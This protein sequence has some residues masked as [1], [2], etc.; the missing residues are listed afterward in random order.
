MDQF[1]LQGKVALITGASRGIGEAIA[2]TFAK[3]GA[4]VIVASRHLDNLEVVV[5]TI[6]GNGGEAFAIAAHMGDAGAGKLLVQQSIDLFGGID[7]VVNNAGI[8]PYWGSLLEAEESLWDKTLDVNLKGYFRLIREATPSMIERGGG[9]VINIASIAGLSPMPGVGLYGISKAAVIMLT[10][11]L[12]IELAPNNI[13]VNAIAPGFVKTR[14]SQAIWG[15][16]TVNQAVIDNT[17]AKRIADV[18]ELM[19]LALYLATPASQYLTGQ[20]IVIDGG[21]TLSTSNYGD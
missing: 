4:Q 7:V 2:Q 11:I 21:L 3:A 10:K 12:A 17:P 19:G 18:D 13:Q 16:E 14:F 5:Q 15:D 6:R 20:T 1:S 9:K 8:N